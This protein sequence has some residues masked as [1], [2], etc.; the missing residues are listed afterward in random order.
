LSGKYVAVAIDNELL[1]LPFNCQ[2]L[3]SHGHGKWFSM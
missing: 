3:T 2:Y 1:Q